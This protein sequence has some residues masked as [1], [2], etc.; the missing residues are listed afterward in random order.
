[1][2]TKEIYKYRDKYLLKCEEEGL[3]DLEEF[4]SVEAGLY[5]ETMQ[6]PLKKVSLSEIRVDDVPMSFYT[7]HRMIFLVP[8]PQIA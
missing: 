1:M 4:C 5:S 6:N 7:S 8:T 3:V 2:K